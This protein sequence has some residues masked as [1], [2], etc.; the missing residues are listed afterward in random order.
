MAG[1]RVGRELHELESEVKSITSKI[2]SNQSEIEDLESD[3]RKAEA[4]LVSD[5]V[6][7]DRR[8]ELLSLTRKLSQDIGSLQTEQ[9]QLERD[10]GSATTEW[11]DARS[12][13]PYQ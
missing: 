11:N 6:G 8:V 13:N 5:G 3:L 4:E 9:R 1:Y 7:K 2:S 12:R 10:L